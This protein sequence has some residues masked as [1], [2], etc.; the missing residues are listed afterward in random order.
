MTR[1]GAIV[2]SWGAPVRGREAAGMHVFG[3]AL[4]YYEEMSKEGHIIGHR[5][6]FDTAGTG[7]MMIIEGLLPELYQLMQR[8]DYIRLQNKASSIV[9]DFRSK[10][11]AGGSDG[12]IQ[13]MM[14]M[15]T[16][17]LSE[18]GYM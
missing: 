9:E 18:L 15:Y 6:Y 3:E 7:G 17:T 4:E 16:E 12:T 11:C 10:L 8:D 1:T 14:G 13:E 2:F 5:E